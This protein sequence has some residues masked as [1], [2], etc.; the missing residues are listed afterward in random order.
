M[1]A[2]I[3]GPHGLLRAEVPEPPAPRADEVTVRVRT[4]GVCRTDLLAADG[5]IPVAPG[6]ILGHEF[7]GT[8][9]RIGKAV[10][11]LRSGDLVTVDPFFPCGDC[12]TCRAGLRPVCPQAGFLGIDRDGAFAE[13]TTV[14]AAAV[15][16][17]PDGIDPRRGAYS[18]PI[19]AALA[20]CEPPPP[21]G[22]GVLVGRNRFSLLAQR[23]L[24]LE[25]GRTV[26]ILTVEELLAR[27]ENSCDFAIECLPTAPVLAACVR[28]IRPGGTL[29]L[30]SRTPRPVDVPLGDVVRK[31]L[32]VQ[33]L[34]YG[35]FRRAVELAADPRLELADLFAPP[36]PWEQA[37]ELLGNLPAD[38][39]GKWFLEPP[40]PAARRERAA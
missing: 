4:V 16:P 27:P 3:R 28:A 26:P 23:L 15:Y 24:A 32:R 1:Q 36:A 6:R 40:C 10:R 39:L 30:K 35:S 19:A 12:P 29:L 34:H 21:A 2:L 8:I 11:D 33:G 22:E 37:A 7:C 5:A 17:L 9:E 25:C 31:G 13:R 14:P 20:L 38:E 18:E